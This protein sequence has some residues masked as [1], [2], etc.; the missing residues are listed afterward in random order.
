MTA[1]IGAFMWVLL[2]LVPVC[3]QA[4]EPDLLSGR[5]GHD[6]SEPAYQA[7]WEVTHQGQDWQARNLA[8]DAASMAYRLSP[9]GRR[10][11]WEKMDWPSQT[12]DNADCVTWGEAE[13]SLLDLLQ[14]PQADAG[15]K[16]GAD[17]VGNALVC[18]VPAAARK[19]IGWLQDSSED[20]FYYD[21]MAGVME[22][23]RLPVD[24]R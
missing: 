2:S 18:H 10:A 7:V 5:Y 12:A 24:K 19:K 8:D 4:A 16:A 17:V 3:A 15:P 1:R 13:A 22:V 11:F 6:A 23:R 14:E 20:W 9:A 21:P